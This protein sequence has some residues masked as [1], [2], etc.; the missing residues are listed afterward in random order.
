MIS[1]TK[2]SHSAES[3]TFGL[4]V[5]LVVTRVSDGRRILFMAGL[6]A[7]G[8]HFRDGP[9]VK[10]Q[11][12]GDAVEDVTEESKGVGNLW[13]CHAQCDEDY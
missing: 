10:A 13:T 4:D 5:D 3:K 7:W 2:W 11:L 6:R 8:D 12:V 9:P 1:I